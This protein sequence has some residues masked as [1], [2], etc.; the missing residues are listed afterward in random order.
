MPRTEAEYCRLQAERMRALA[1]QCIDLNI[2]AQIEA[3]AKDWA[4]LA[5]VKEDRP[6]LH[7]FKSA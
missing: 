1:E 5:L 7:L 2:R 4:N 6:T 3:M